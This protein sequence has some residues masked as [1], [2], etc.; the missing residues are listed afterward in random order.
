MRT[1]C[2]ILS[3]WHHASRRSA[4][5]TTARFRSSSRATSPTESFSEPLKL[6]GCGL[7]QIRSTRA[8]MSSCETKRSESIEQCPGAAKVSGFLLKAIDG[9]NYFRRRALD[10]LAR[11]LHGV[12]RDVQA[13][14]GVSLLQGRNSGFDFIALSVAALR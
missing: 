4:I 3:S 7:F 1:M 2:S 12:A 14:S 13:L 9:G 8:I 10:D 6:A 11:L 5:V